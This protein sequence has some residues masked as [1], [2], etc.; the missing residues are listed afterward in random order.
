MNPE[1]LGLQLTTRGRGGQIY[2]LNKLTYLS[3]LM[4]SIY[5][6]GNVPPTALP[7]SQQ[8]KYLDSLNNL[9]VNTQLVWKV[10]SVLTLTAFIAY[11][12]PSQMA[13]TLVV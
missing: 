9:K 2:G 5:C 7:F 8:E 3:G 6:Q 12:K 13:V 1:Q 4:S 11:L 10:I